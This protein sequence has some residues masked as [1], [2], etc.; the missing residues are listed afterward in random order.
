M[1]LSLG[2]HLSNLDIDD[3]FIVK[4]SDKVCMLVSQSGAAALNLFSLDV[5]DILFVTAQKVAGMCRGV[6]IP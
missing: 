3:L 4:S 5:K 6:H 2:R 1:G